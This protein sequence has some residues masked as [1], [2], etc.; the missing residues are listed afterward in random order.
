MPTI[1]ANGIDLH[2]VEA[3][4]GEPLVLVMGFGGDHLAWGFQLAALSAR[5]RVVTFDNRGAGRSSAPDVPYTTPMMADDTVAVMDHLGIARAHVLGVSLGGMIAQEVAL[6][7]PERV[8]SLQLHGTAARADRYLRALMENLRIVRHGLGAEAAQ[9]AMALW[10]FGPSTFE[11]R[12][13]LID[14]LLYAAKIQPYPQSDVGF[15]RQGDAVMSHDALARLHR[16]TMPTLVSVGEEDQLT[17]AR[18][19]REIAGAIAHAD[20]QTISRAGHAS[21]WEKSSEFNALCLNFLAK[22]R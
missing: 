1:V 2:Y 19:A 20:F 10:L 17:P 8:R 7:H 15:V 5:Y 22:Q 14:S 12:A 3:G 6:A 9:R 4:A 13:D 21:F 18:F 16:L 11:E